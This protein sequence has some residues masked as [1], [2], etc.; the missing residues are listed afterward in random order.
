MTRSLTEKDLTD[1]HPLFIFLFVFTLWEASFAIKEHSDN[2]NCFIS[3]G[4][5]IK[6]KAELVS[7]PPYGQNMH[8]PTSKFIN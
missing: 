2:E 4:L 6:F 3:L 1:N 5:L 8:T 7:F